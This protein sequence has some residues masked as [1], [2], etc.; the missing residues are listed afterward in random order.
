MNFINNWKDEIWGCNHAFKDSI[1][2]SLI[3]SVHNWCVL[4]ALEYRIL[5]NLNYEIL[6]N[7]PLN[8]SINAFIKY[9]GWASGSELIHEALLRGYNEIWLAGFCFIDNNEKDLYHPEMIMVTGN[10]RKQW[11]HIKEEFPDKLKNIHFVPYN[12]E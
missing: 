4:E 2:F 9:R 10:F 12:K 3:A 5:N 11:E 7:I 1:N 8:N 6:H